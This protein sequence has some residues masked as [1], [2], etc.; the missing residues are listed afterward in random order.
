MAFFIDCVPL[1]CADPARLATVWTT[2]LGYTVRAD[3]DG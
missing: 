1:D 3:M 2:A